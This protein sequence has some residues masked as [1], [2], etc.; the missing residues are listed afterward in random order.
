MA[1]SRICHFYSHTRL[2]SLDNF[3]FFFSSTGAMIITTTTKGRQAPQ[4][5]GGIV[6]L[7]KVIN[8]G[9]CTRAVVCCSSPH[10]SSCLASSMEHLPLDVLVEI[11]LNFPI[12][13]A[14]RSCSRVCKRFHQA[15]RSEAYARAALQRYIIHN[16]DTNP[17]LIPSPLPADVHRFMIDYLTDQLL[18]DY[19]HRHLDAYVRIANESR[20]Y[21]TPQ[22][23][24][25]QLHRTKSILSASDFAQLRNSSRKLCLESLPMKLFYSELCC[26]GDKE[27]E[28]T[29]F[30]VTHQTFKL[31]HYSKSAYRCLKTISYLHRYPYFVAWGCLK[32]AIA[33]LR[34]QCSLRDDGRRP[35]LF[36]VLCC[37]PKWWVMVLVTRRFTVT[38]AV[39]L[40]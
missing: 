14:I 20:V 3:F 35:C 6:C 7:Y 19:L 4:D 40:K 10:T 30:V 9:L 17:V 2:L 24:S 5:R 11:F 13:K 34:H 38:L 26:P 8:T 37:E 12:R 18:H 1:R 29:R 16:R 36:D 22:S 32:R 23:V 33:A 25:F 27:G 31:E 28:E 15:L 21:I 39:H